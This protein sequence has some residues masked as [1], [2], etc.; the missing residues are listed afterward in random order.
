MVQNLKDQKLKVPP[1]NL[2]AERALLGSILL[3]AEV[4]PS[5]VEILKPVDFYSKN[6]ST[7]FDS[8]VSLFEK[9]Q[10]VDIVTLKNNLGSKG[11]LEDVGGDYYLSDIVNSTVTS[12]NA[13]SYAKIV[14]E[15]AVL[16]SVIRTAEWIVES[17]YDRVEDTEDFLDRAE[18]DIFKASED[19]TTTS[20]HHMRDMVS[21]VLR[22]IEGLTEDKRLTRGVPSGFKDIDKWTLGFQPSDLIIIAARPGMGK[23][24]LCLN[25]AFNAAVK[26]KKGVAIFS[27]E[28]S[29]EQLA[30]R[31]LCSHARV[32][33]YRLRSGILK[34]EEY[35]DI[36]K[37]AGVLADAPIF[38]DDSPGIS[39]LELRAKA[40]RLKYELKDK[41]SLIVVDY[42]QLMRG[43]GKV[44]TREQ[45]ISEISRSLKFLA[46]ELNMPVI[47]ISQLNRALEARDDKR[48]R[49]SDLRESGAIEQDADLILFI[50]RDELYR[51][52]DIPED[53]RGMAEVIVG[54]NRNGPVGKA[55]L[56]FLTQFTKFEDL[57]KGY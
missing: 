36:A 11:I 2:E 28:M 54:K 19:R 13:A 53:E 49:L 35:S 23:T 39:S 1:H 24:A 48:P 40:R 20:Y 17:G 29:K 4:L 42:L 22:E 30:M 10:P 50:Y 57:A 56:V 38:I 33:L 27:L 5:V 52:G 15:K 34:S 41:L 47:A 25:I 26:W 31:M 18:A 3:N 51:K 44:N 21:V 32:D 7:I 37:A 6:H 43:R 8:I 14:K 55:E 46:K 9:S 45:E 16:R 12:A